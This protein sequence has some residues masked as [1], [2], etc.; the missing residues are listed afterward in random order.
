[1]AS[2]D[3]ARPDFEALKR[4]QQALRESEARYRGLVEGSIQG[5]SIHQ[6]F[7]VRFANPAFARM[8]GYDAPA[9]VIGRNALTLVAAEDR[10]RLEAYSLAR[11]HGEPGPS[12]HEFQGMRRDGARVW[13]EGVISLTTWDSRPATLAT[14]FDLTE[15]KQLE[16]Q[17]L[18]SQK[19]EVVGRLAGGIAH[20]FNNLLTVILG[21]AELLLHRLGPE[22]PARRDVELIGA[23]G[24]RA[25][26]L[27][28]QLLA[29]SRRQ[30]LK[31][32]VLDLN[33]VV[34]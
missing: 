27:T 7:I 20:D 22:G 21:R 14:L 25:V 8:F 34:S 19:M 18:Q 24:R 23:T 11:L 6:D 3:S 17:F 26:A 32:Q 15:R 29:V 33:A 4:A 30:V 16:Q 10:D 5:I 13:I 12:R 31:P 1:M 28:Q 9:Q 2:V